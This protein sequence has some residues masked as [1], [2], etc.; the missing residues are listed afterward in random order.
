LNINELLKHFDACVETII[1]EA[2]HLAVDSDD[3][4]YAYN[5]LMRLLTPELLISNAD[6]IA[7]AAMEIGKL[8]NSHKFNYANFLK[9]ILNKVMNKV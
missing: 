4:V 1:H 7:W 5:P 8:N 6:N 3:V 9:E 2:S